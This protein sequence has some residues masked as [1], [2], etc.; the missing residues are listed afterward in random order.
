M[1]NV[2]LHGQMGKC[3]VV[4]YAQKQAYDTL[5]HLSVRFR[6]QRMVF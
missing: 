1:L 2:A 5:H 3:C 4:C 6:D